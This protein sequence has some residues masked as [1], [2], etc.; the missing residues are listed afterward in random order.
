MKKTNEIVRETITKDF[1]VFY[2]YKKLLI[3]REKNTK[4]LF[5]VKWGRNML[6][7]LEIRR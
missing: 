3:V 2:R 4:R 1:E 5:N 7:P 6:I